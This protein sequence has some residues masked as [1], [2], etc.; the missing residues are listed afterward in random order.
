MRRFGLVLI[1]LVAACSR[2]RALPAPEGL[3]E[4]DS[5]VVACRAEAAR[6]PEVRELQRR[7]PI[8]FGLPQTEIDDEIAAVRAS[9][10]RVC[11]L[12]EGLMAPSAGGVEAVRAPRFSAPDPASVG[13]AALP[14]PPPRTQGY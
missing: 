4:T 7:R 5:R 13:P 11:L 6:A 2:E 1:L 12:R 10:F 8:Q 9:A 14:P 3:A